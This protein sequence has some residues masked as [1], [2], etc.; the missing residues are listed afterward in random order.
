MGGAKGLGMTETVMPR[1]E[2]LWLWP[3]DLEA[4]ETVTLRQGDALVF[5]DELRDVVPAGEG[6]FV[7]DVEVE[8]DELGVVFAHERIDCRRQFFVVEGFG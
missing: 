3:G 1:G 2:S 4:T 8:G 5:F 6:L 7:E